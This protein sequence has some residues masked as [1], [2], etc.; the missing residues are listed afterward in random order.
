MP[1]CS[2]VKRIVS[3]G[4]WEP[5]VLCK[6]GAPDNAFLPRMSGG[7]LKTEINMEEIR[8]KKPNERQMP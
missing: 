3:F 6:S 7:L 2:A 4:D 8:A 5:K 1:P